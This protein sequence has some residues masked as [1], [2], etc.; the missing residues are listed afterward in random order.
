MF[1]L[2]TYPLMTEVFTKD[3]PVIRLSSDP[4]EQQGFMML[5]AGVVKSVRNPKAHRLITQTDPQRTLEWLGFASVL[6]RLLDEGKVAREYLPKNERKKEKK[7]QKRQPDGNA[8]TFLLQKE[9][10]AAELYLK[11]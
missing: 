1:D 9:F 8:Q 10:L 6:F 5:F 7:R 3:D 11:V 4:E 2:D